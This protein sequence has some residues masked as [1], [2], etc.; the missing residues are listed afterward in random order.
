[1]LMYT[2]NFFLQAIAGKRREIYSY[3]FCQE[4]HIFQMKIRFP[5]KILGIVDSF[6]VEFLL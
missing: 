2:L 5:L 6:L 1:M 4:L 3:L